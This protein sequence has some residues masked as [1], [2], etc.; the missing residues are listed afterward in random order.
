ME[1]NLTEEFSCDEIPFSLGVEGR[2]RG[3]FST[4]TK[5]GSS[6]TALEAENFEEVPDGTKIV[7]CLCPDDTF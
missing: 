1:T 4:G 3:G 6:L 5:A 2:L 7:G